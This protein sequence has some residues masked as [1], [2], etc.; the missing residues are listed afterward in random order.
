[1]AQAVSIPT[2]DDIQTI[3]D[4]RIANLIT[5]HKAEVS[6]L[7]IWYKHM[8]INEYGLTQTIGNPLSNLQVLGPILT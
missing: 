7:S 2:S 5:D 3:A 8:S 1:M 6:K 4:R